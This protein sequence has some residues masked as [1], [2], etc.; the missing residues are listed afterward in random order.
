M[1]AT[2]TLMGTAMAGLLLAAIQPAWAGDK[3]FAGLEPIGQSEMSEQRAMNAP[4]NLLDPEI[5]QMNNTSQSST[6]DGASIVNSGSMQNGTIGANSF[7]RNRG[8]FTVMQNSGNQ[9]NMNSAMSVNI[10]LQ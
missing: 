7:E 9:V 10:T 4:Q 8:N 3:P 2:K 5:L 1:R 6:N